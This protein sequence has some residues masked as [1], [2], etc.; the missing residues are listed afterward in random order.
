MS[1]PRKPRYRTINGKQ[2][3]AA[4][5]ARGSLSIGLDKRMTWLAAASGKRVR[6]LKFSDAAIWFC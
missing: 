3:K 1:Q 6:S 2:Y 5:P 4:L